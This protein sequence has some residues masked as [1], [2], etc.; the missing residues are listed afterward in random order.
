MSTR[1][2]IVTHNSGDAPFRAQCT[3]IHNALVA[4]GWVQTSDTGQMNPA[5]VTRPATTTIA[6]YLIYRM[7]DALQATAPFF[8]KV[9]VGTGIYTTATNFYFSIGTATDGAGTLTGN[10]SSELGHGTGSSGNYTGK[11]FMSGTDNSVQAAFWPDLALPLFLSVERSRDSNG[12]VTGDGAH[13]IF[14]GYVAGNQQQYVP[15]TGGVPAVETRLLCYAPY[16]DGTFQGGGYKAVSCI[17]PVRGAL[18]NPI[19]GMMVTGSCIIHGVTKTVSRY[20]VNRTYL[21]AYVTGYCA[22]RSSAA[23]VLILW[24]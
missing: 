8:L 22:T 1:I 9:R 6:G 17:Y 15:S 12:V 7:A 24:E 3:A 21:A 4:F 13:L 18:L 14:S 2:E 20:G 16:V 23:M 11:F 5:T 19:L 10:Y